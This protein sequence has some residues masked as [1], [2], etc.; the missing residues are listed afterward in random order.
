M[1]SN[2][3]ILC[4]SFLLL[5][6]VFP[7]IRVFSSES[8]LRIK[9]PKYWSVN[10]SISPSNEYS[11]L[12]SYRIDW[13]DLLAVQGTLKSLLQDH[14]LK[15]SVLIYIY[16]HIHTYACMFLSLSLIYCEIICSK[17]TLNMRAMDVLRQNQAKRFLRK[18]EKYNEEINQIP[19]SYLV[20]RAILSGFL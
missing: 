9:W 20:K 17:W 2:R 10:F 12:I 15:A 4:H 8:T 11:G 19:K 16:I 3:L 1:L 13:F 18:V 7:S 14:N 5:P 6:S